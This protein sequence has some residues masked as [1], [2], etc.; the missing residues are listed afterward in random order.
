MGRGVLYGTGGLD[1]RGYS[2]H[3]GTQTES[4]E[5]PRSLSLLVLASLILA[6]GGVGWDVRASSPLE[7]GIPTFSHTG[8]TPDTLEGIDR[9]TQLI[10]NRFSGVARSA[11]AR[12][13]RMGGTQDRYCSGGEGS[14]CHGGDPDRGECNAGVPCHP[15]EEWFVDGLLEEALKYP[16]SGFLMGQALYALT[17]FGRLQEA[18]ELV[19]EC[20]AEGWWCEALQGYVLYAYAPLV[21]VEAHFRRAMREAP[22]D[23]LCS[24]GDAMWLLGKWDQRSSGPLHLPDGREETVDW[25]CPDRVAASDTIFWWADPLFSQ[26]G[27][28]R[29][30]VHMARAISAHLFQEIRRTLRGSDLPQEN[31][32][33]DWA[34]RIRRGQWD[35]YERLPGRNAVRYWTSEEAA[36]Y[37]F[38]PEVEPGNLSHPTWRIRGD[39]QDEGYTPE[40]GPLFTIE[41]QIARF[42][43]GD[44]L[45]LA[46]AGELEDTRL[47]RALDATSFL[48]L[49]DGPGSLPLQVVKETRRET[50][51]LLGRAPH[52][53]YVTIFEVITDIGIGLARQSISPLAKNGA[54]ISDLLLYAPSQGDEPHTVL[55]ATPTMLGS[56]RLETGALLGV[57]WEVYG[58]PEGETL[59]F[60]LTLERESGNLVERLRGLF[61]GGSQEGRGRVAWTE[62]ATGETHPRGIT[63][64]LSDLRSGEYALV[65]TVQW[66]GQPPLERRRALKVR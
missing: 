52:L 59:A 53:D 33:H 34:M 8:V 65:L 28:D 49:S 44:S 7:P 55:D 27:N 11:S 5:M 38:I 43:E 6:V 15:N 24:F 2:F 54:E 48:F 63:L 23:I 51:V 60:E 32:D 31:Q 14:V 17:K 64:N 35:S 3:L 9:A 36:R 45:L 16:T 22:P 62:Q 57:F 61:P 41:V 4:K 25:A 66:P 47:R 10:R 42:R 30:T 39:I 58:V 21:D 46:V 56:A 19:N 29:W 12:G 50:P 37:H 26:E 40:Y 13:N 20:E 1:F 18:E